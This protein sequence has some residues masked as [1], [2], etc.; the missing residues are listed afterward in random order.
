MRVEVLG[1]GH[2]DRPGAVAAHRMAGEPAA[3]APRDRAIVLVDIGDEVVG[4]EG[5]EIAGGDRSPV[6]RAAELGQ[7]IGHHDDELAAS[8]GIMR[9]RL[10]NVHEIVEILPVDREAVEVID[11]RVVLLRVLAVARREHHHRGVRSGLLPSRLPAI[12]GL[13]TAIFSTVIPS[14]IGGGGA[15]DVL[16]GGGRCDQQGCG[17]ERGQFLQ[18]GTS[19]P[20]CYLSR[21]SAKNGSSSLRIRSRNARFRDR[22]RRSSTRA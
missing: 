14:G 1:M 6:H 15:G 21:C 19:S 10:R 22:R 9:D 2:A 11:H 20:G 8:G 3:F 17:G 12:A 5:A 4:D 16:R 13:W 18:H 7:R